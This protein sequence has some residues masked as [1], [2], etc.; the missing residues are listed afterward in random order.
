MREIREF[1][2]VLTRIVSNEEFTS[3][4]SKNTKATVFES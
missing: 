4:T 1:K 3:Y 2:M